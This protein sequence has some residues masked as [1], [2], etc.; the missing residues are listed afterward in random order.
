M[1]LENS[2]LQ[3]LQASTSDS[4]V[5]QLEISGNI[6]NCQSSSEV[7]YLVQFTNEDIY[8]EWYQLL[9]KQIRHLS[10]NSDVG[11]VSAVPL[12][13]SLSSSSITSPQSVSSSSIFSP[14]TT[15][16][17][18]EPPPPLPPVGK[19]PIGFHNQNLVS[20]ILSTRPPP[21]PPQHRAKGQISQANLI[22]SIPKRTSYW[23][24]H[25]LTPHSPY[26]PYND[27]LPNK[28]NDSIIEQNED[29]QLLNV[30]DSYH[31]KFPGNS[32]DKNCKSRK[33]SN[34]SKFLFQTECILF[35]SKIFFSLAIEMDLDGPEPHQFVEIIENIQQYLTKDAE[36]LAHKK[37]SNMTKQS[38]TKL[39]NKIS[40]LSM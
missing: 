21:P 25:L 13:C 4:G 10:P 18:S 31:R 16:S 26:R 23:S 28:S 34:P 37:K 12:T 24:Q 22:T 3:V 38:L 36:K 32:W 39:A 5:Y 27:N 19:P 40:K 20:S 33:L 2:R 14:Q 6:V 30:I 29:M 9:Q 17:C 11:N 1:Q 8:K 35:I 15:S 7:T